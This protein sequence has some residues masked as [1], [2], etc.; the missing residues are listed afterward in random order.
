MES[1]RAALLFHGANRFQA[2]LLSFD[3]RM[4]VRSACF[5]ASGH[6]LR[7]RAPRMISFRRHFLKKVITEPGPSEGHPQPFS[8]S[9]SLCTENSF[10]GKFSGV[11]YCCY[12]VCQKIIPS[13]SVFPHCRARPW[14]GAGNQ[15]PGTWRMGR[16]NVRRCPLTHMAFWAGPS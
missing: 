5:L 13:F 8:A 11:R 12:P 15:S 10:V 14:P 16:G 4:V 9:L 6:K 3:H 2:T 1:I 7:A